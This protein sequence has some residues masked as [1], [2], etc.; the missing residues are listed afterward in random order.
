MK[1]IFRVLAILAALL[2]V[3]GAATA[4]DVRSERLRFPGGANGI[5]VQGRISGYE[6]V[7]YVLG[8]R[9]GQR[10]SVTLQSRNRFAYFNVLAPGSDSAL[11]VGSRDGERFDTALPVS[12][13][14]VV[15][16]PGQ[17]GIDK[18]EHKDGGAAIDQR[19]KRTGGDAV[20]RI[21][22]AGIDGRKDADRP[23][24]ANG[25]IQENHAYRQRGK[26]AL[27]AKSPQA[28]PCRGGRQ[29]GHAAHRQ[30]A[31]HQTQHRPV[32]LERG[33]EVDDRFENEG[34]AFQRKVAEAYAALADANPD[35]I[36]RV[37]GARGPDEVAVDVASM[38]DQRFSL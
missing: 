3:Q 14:D 27:A 13:D 31:P 9:A 11:F 7:D 35:R 30:R 4:Q 23:Q 37:D 6:T 36:L 25:G 33:A 22:R 16:E 20:F 18:H 21:E 12:G 34:V 15:G 19:R 10:M 1:G 32:A 29:N 5:E 17:I 8:A 28:R 24:C 38:I 2:S 26:T